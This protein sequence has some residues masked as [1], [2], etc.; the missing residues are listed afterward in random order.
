MAAPTPQVMVDDDTYKEGLAGSVGI[1]GHHEGWACSGQEHSC[2]GTRQGWQVP[3]R[4]GGL[5]H[6]VLLHPVLNEKSEGAVGADKTIILKSRTIKS[7][8]H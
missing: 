7:M 5:N 4:D 2:G 6:L 8:L 1:Q 3:T